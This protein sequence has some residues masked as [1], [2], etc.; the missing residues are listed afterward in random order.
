MIK[1][2]FIRLSNVTG[3]YQGKKELKDISLCLFEGEIHALCGDNHADIKIL[4]DILLGKTDTFGGHIYYREKEIKNRQAEAF[5]QTQ[6]VCACYNSEVVPDIS[7][8]ENIFLLNGKGIKGQWLS[9]KKMRIKTQM[10]F[11]QLGIDEVDYKTPPTELTDY[12]KRLLLIAKAVS[13]KPQLLILDNITMNLHILQA[14]KIL[15][16][17]KKISQSG[18][19]VLYITDQS[20]E[21]MQIADRLS[22]MHDGIISGT[23]GVHGKS[24]SYLSNLMVSQMFAKK[25]NP[26]FKKEELLRVE[27]LSIPGRN[28][29]SFTLYKGEVLFMTGHRDAHLGEI[30]KALCGDISH[31][32][33]DVYLENKLVRIRSL[34]DAAKLRI[35]YIP[36]NDLQGSVLY[37]QSILENITLQMLDTVSN[38]GIINRKLERYVAE[39]WRAKM[40]MRAQ[41][42][43]LSGDID[44]MQKKK[45]VLA[46]CLAA[47]PKVLIVNSLTSGIS[48]PLRKLLM[49]QIQP[50]L[51]TGSGVL[52]LANETH[53][54]FE[55]ADRMLVLTNSD[56]CAEIG[57]DENERELLNHLSRQ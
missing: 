9:P 20:S 40:E 32:T 34:H 28:S 19:S 1:K 56:I 18:I 11:L 23:S 14:E 7:I 36:E 3:E 50:L 33:G 6:C 46:R 25:Y 26:I 5:F 35:G 42:D 47:R 41:P 2:D 17:I 38:H 48:Y 54:A 57:G 8:A 15:N 31:T 52:I 24:R 45:M 12:Q 13:S 30:A 51:K 22:V 4:M 29:L 21:V 10:L 43:T 49:E 16:I 27:S 37:E 55:Y 39:E 53:D 44:N